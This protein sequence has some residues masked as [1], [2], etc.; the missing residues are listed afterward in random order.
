MSFFR[1][2]QYDLTE[3][4]A[5][6]VDT[7][8]SNYL[9]LAFAQNNNGICLLKKV[10]AFD[11]SQVYYTVSVAVTRI[12]AMVV[13]NGLIFL[14][15]THATIFSLAYSVTNPLTTFTSINKP[16]GVTESPTAITTGNSA[17]VYF[18]TP[19]VASASVSYVVQVTNVHVYSATIELLVSGVMVRD[20]SSITIDGSNNLWVTTNTRPTNLIRVWKVGLVWNI[21]ETVLN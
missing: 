16:V 5:I 6:C 1:D 9:W 10:S 19:G 13:T 15:V 8:N 17:F 7:T 2:Y 14:A 18:L 12:N 3:V 4:T 21:E 20:A 11:L